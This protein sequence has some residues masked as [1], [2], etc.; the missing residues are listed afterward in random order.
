MVMGDRIH[1]S[2]GELTDIPVEVDEDREADPSAAED[3][4]GEDAGPELS[5]PHIEPAA[6]TDAPGS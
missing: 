1:P 5:E 6:L 4:P 3:V 2:H